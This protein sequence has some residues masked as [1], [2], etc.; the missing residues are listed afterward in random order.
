LKPFCIYLL[1][2]THAHECRI[3]ITLSLSGNANAEFQAQNIFPLYALFAR[4]ISDVLVEGVSLVILQLMQL[5]VCA[6]QMIS[7]LMELHYDAAF[8]TI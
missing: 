4:S 6:H 3:Q 5:K 8:S 1:T 2:F 7:S